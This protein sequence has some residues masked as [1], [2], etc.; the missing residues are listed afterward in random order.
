MH[1]QI[2]LACARLDVGQRDELGLCDGLVSL[3]EHALL[4]QDL[5]LVVAR[6]DRL[7]VCHD[8]RDVLV[9]V[10][11]VVFI[12]QRCTQLNR[13]HHLSQQCY[14]VRVVWHFLI[15]HLAFQQFRQKSAS[16]IF[17]HAC[18]V[19][20]SCMHGLLCP[21]TP[22]KFASQER[23]AHL[24]ALVQGEGLVVLQ[25]DDTGQELNSLQH[26]GGGVILQLLKGLIQ[27]EDNCCLL[28]V[29][30]QRLNLLHTRQLHSD[31]FAQ[32]AHAHLC[33]PYRCPSVQGMDPELQFVGM[34]FI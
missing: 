10:H 13:L 3:A 17:L 25:L 28:A 12:S 27:E 30:Q 26:C 32:S 19:K 4:E 11:D 15:R 23:L 24:S 20:F 22:A 33:P 6:L 5:G 7:E 8:V 2:S 21:M 34:G 9:V 16:V 18:M 1:A 14:S 31:S 29:P